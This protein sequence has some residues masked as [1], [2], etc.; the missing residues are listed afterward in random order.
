MLG[1]GHVIASC[2][3]RVL[4]VFLLP[5]ALAS[6]WALEWWAFAL[7]VGYLDSQAPPPQGYLG[8]GITWVL[9]PCLTSVRVTGSA[10]AGGG[11]KALGS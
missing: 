2:A 10:S 7:Y 6:A 8:A 4:S 11:G 1:H 5:V 9:L 3:F